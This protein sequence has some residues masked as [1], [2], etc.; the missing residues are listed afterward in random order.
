M[1]TDD[2]SFCQQQVRAADRDRYFADL[3]APDDL[4]PHLFA[5]HAFAIEIIRIRDLVHEPMAGEIRLQWWFDALEGQ[6]RGE[7]AANPVA[8]ALLDTVDRCAVPVGRL[9][10][11][12]DA[13]RLDLYGEPIASLAEL[14]DYADASAGTMLALSAFILDPSAPVEWHASAGGFALAGIR[15]LRRLAR[16]ASRGQI[17]LPGELLDRHR[18]DRSDILA[19]R[20]TAAL[21]A[22]L[23]EMQS[24]IR[25]RYADFLAAGLPDAVRPAFLPVALV[26]A[27]LD[28]MEHGD[29]AFAASGLSP[30]RRQWLLWRT[31][32]RGFR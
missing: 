20:T 18:V 29:D 17:V 14:T 8:A 21:K 9:Q 26:P 31:A 32:R 22:A 7:V 15:I 10:R 4:R 30:L 24:L 16:A 2:Y 3:F 1:L 28:R 27:S 11:L 19:G 12:I 13:H 6:G 25:A 5:L 23:G